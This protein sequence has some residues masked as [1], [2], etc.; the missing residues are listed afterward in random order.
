[1]KNAI[2]IEIPESLGGLGKLEPFQGAWARLKRGWMDEVVAPRPIKANTPRADKRIDS[3]EA[4]IAKCEPHDGMTVSFHHHLRAG[5]GVVSKVI[6]ILHRMGIR[7][8]TLASSSLTS[9][10]DPLVPYVQDGTITRIW[11]SGIRDGLGTAITRGDLAYPVVIQSHGGR[12]RAIKTGRIKIDLAILA[13]SAADCEGNATGCHGPSAFGSIGYAMADAD[14]ARYVIVVTDNIV[15]YPCL[16]MSI[17]QTTV[18]YVV[19]VDTIGDPSKIA[20]GTTRITK[21][22]MDLR[23]AEMAASV[24]EHSGYMEPGFSFQVGA[25]GASLAAAKFLREA[26]KKRGI[27]GGFALG[28]VTSYIV[29][30]LYEGLFEVVFDVQSFDAAVSSSLK[31]N[32]LHIEISCDQYGNPYNCGAITN[33]LDVV[34]LGALEVDEQFNVNVI[35]GSEGFV[36]GASGGHSDTA[37]GAALT[38][39]VC[40]SFRGRIPIIKERAHSVVTPGESVDVV[41]TERGICVNPRHAGLA[42]RLRKANLPVREIHDLRQQVDAITGGPS[43]IRLTDKI[44]GLIEYR[45]GTIIDIIRQVKE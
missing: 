36:R 7:D 1:M 6:E 41:V 23:I 21:S 27:K 8:I 45:D 20:T 4:A 5:D 3:L 24:I 12:V 22:P 2:G 19:R 17:K 30:M 38:V 29:D 15:D 35:T 16:P 33:K 28:G 9:A 31:D 26:M 14:Y 13:A 18:D 37:A 10:H 40:P 11:S 34:V 39:V 32:P 42:D 25:G 44:V 43:P